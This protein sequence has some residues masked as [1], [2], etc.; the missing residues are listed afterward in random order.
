[1]K[2]KLLKDGKLAL[3]QGTMGKGNISS[4]MESSMKESFRKENFMEKAF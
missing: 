3:I 1:M 4:I 2:E